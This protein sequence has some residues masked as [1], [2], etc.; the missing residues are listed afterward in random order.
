MVE[1]LEHKPTKFGTAE[2]GNRDS[3]ARTVSCHVWL[4]TEVF[5]TVKDMADKNNLSL[6]RQI[7]LLTQK[8]L[9]K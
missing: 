1:A 8:G 6:S 5:H 4:P 9:R 2:G 7:S 3:S